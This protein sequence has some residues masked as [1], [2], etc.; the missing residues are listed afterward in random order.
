MKKDIKFLIDLGIGYLTLNR[1]INTLSNGESQKLKLA[2]SMGNT[3]NEL[4]YIMDEPTQGFH[5]RDVNKII[6]AVKNIVSNN[7]TAIVGYEEQ[8]TL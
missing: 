1:G 8:N 6:S 3:L 2:K 7:N 4:I 5:A